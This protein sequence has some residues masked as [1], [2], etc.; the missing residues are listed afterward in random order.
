MIAGVAE[1]L[2]R[3]NPAMIANDPVQV[4]ILPAQRTVFKYHE[5]LGH[6]CLG[7]QTTSIMVSISGAGKTRAR[8]AEGAVRRAFRELPEIIPEVI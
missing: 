4:K 3:G 1:E 5:E 8:R 7:E 2:E 6:D